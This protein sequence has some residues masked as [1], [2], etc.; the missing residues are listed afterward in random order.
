MQKQPCCAESKEPKKEEPSKDVGKQ[1]PPKQEAKPQQPSESKPEPKSGA[2][3]QTPVPKPDPK[4]Q[5]AQPGKV[6]PARCM[7]MHRCHVLEIE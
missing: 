1:A 3:P 4:L 2:K 6:T 7:D 5:Q